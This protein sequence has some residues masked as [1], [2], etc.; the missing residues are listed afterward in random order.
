MHEGKNKCN[1]AFSFKNLGR[2]G[3]LED[4]GVGEEFYVIKIDCGDVNSVIPD[5]NTARLR[6]FVST[7]MDFMCV[8]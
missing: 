7:V 6:D 5:Q 1:Q 3:H 4:E 2:G 8:Y